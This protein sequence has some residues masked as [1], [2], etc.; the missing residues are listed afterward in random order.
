VTKSVLPAAADE[1]LEY[2]MPRYGTTIE[3]KDKRGKRL[4]NLAWEGDGFSL[5]RV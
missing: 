5:K 2:E 1:G 4:Y 3:V